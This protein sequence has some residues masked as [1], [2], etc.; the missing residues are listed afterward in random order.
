VCSV[1]M[2]AGTALCY[3]VIFGPIVMAF[4]WHATLC[5]GTPFDLPDRVSEVSPPSSPDIC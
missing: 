3:T 5:Q 1:A 2:I 4:Y